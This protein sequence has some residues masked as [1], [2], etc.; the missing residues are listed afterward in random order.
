M[1]KA[2]DSAPI[3]EPRSETSF[4]AWSSV[5]VVWSFKNWSEVEMVCRRRLEG[6]NGVSA[7]KF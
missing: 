1:V 4:W 7:I 5:I 2:A 3:E 6:W